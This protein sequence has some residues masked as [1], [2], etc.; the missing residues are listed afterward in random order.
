VQPKVLE[1]P[2]LQ[3]IYFVSHF[4]NA[5]LNL[6]ITVLTSSYIIIHYRVKESI[7][8]FVANEWKNAFRA[9]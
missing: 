1:N 6:Y 2:L 8:I 5:G 7:L 4:Q 3:V 9:A